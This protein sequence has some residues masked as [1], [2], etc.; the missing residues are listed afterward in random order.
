VQR[1]ETV[2]DRT[3]HTWAELTWSDAGELL[4]LRVPGAT[5]HRASLEHPILG[6]AA[7][8]TND[9]GELLTVMS[10]IDWARPTQIPAIAEP[11]R[12]PA[13]AGGV[14]INVLALLSRSG[15]SFR[16]PFGDEPNNVSD[17]SRTN[18][19]LTALRYAG[20]W[21][22]SALYQALLR[23]FTTTA[24]EAEF[25]AGGIERA[26][27]GARDVLPFEFFA[28]PHERIAIAGGHVEIRT[29][30]ER[31]V[32]DGVAYARDGGV[33]RLVENRAEVWFGDAPWAEVATFAADGSVLAGPH[34]LPACTSDAIG[35]AF[36]AGLREAIAELVAE[37]VAAPL[38]DA[39]RA[40][41]VH[42]PIVWA[43]LGA[44]AARR[45]REGFAVHAALWERL[46]PSG[47]ARVALAIAEALV[48]VVT[49]AVVADVG[50]MSQGPASGAMVKP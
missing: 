30:L 43:D 9:D 33:A 44:R 28:A 16:A 7:P 34:P 6:A 38:A 3:G 19:D 27:R 18:S 12:L 48:P 35:K 31:A 17:R 2:T 14:I 46:A 13:G 50:V 5:V 39:A 36:P 49:L 22:T 26:L 15:V 37:A 32:I 25:T 20:P 42:G 1:L 40:A 24:S 11:G 21:P 10:A 23:S 29:G 8:I 41:V 4:A 47:L 45:E